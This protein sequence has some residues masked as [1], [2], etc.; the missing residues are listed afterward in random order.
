MRNFVT[1]RSNLDAMPITRW[2]NVKRDNKREVVI[3]SSPVYAIEQ[4]D[5]DL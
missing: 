2:V 5:K 1:E 4:L 3:H